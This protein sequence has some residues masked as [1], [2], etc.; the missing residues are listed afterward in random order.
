MSFQDVRPGQK[1]S[2][3]QRQQQQQ[4]NGGDS[5]TTS[6]SSAGGGGS[7]Y[8]GRNGSS[9]SGGGRGWSDASR[10]GAREGGF[11]SAGPLRT[12]GIGAGGGAAALHHGGLG[13]ISSSSRP[14]A[15]GV[16]GGLGGGSSGGGKVGDY[17]MIY[18]VSVVPRSAAVVSLLLYMRHGSW[19]DTLAIRPSRQRA[20]VLPILPL[21][22]RC[23]VE[24]V[25]CPSGFS[26]LALAG[27]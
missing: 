11:G 17:L 24:R 19:S 16:G 9:S 25:C 12:G 7:Y 26:L 15:G 8:S 3:W 27:C 21:P 18:M 10:Q 14:A 20:Y 5:R 6:S 2:R 23:C 1:P 4:Q 22:C 13:S